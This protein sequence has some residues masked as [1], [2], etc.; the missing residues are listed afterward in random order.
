MVNCDLHLS[1]FIFR[2]KTCLDLLTSEWKE[3]S[4]DFNQGAFVSSISIKVVADSC[5][6]QICVNGRQFP[7]SFARLFYIVSVARIFSFRI[8]P[9]RLAN[10]NVR[11]LGI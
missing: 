2:K 6:A 3:P 9:L 11:A 10:D 8:T 1:I 5:T 7:V 4:L